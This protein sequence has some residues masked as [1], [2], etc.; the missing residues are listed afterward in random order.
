MRAKIGI[1]VAKIQVGVSKNQ[2]LPQ[3]DVSFSYTVDGLGGSHEDAFDQVTKNDYHEYAV[4]VEFELPVGNRARRAALQR[5]KLQYAQAIAGLKQA[6]EQ[7][8]LDTNTAVRQVKTALWQV[9]PSLNSANATEDQVDSII[10]RAERK[11]YLTLNNELSTRQA[12]AQ[13]RSSLLSSLIDYGIA[14]VD[15]ERSKGTLLKYNNI[16]LAFDDSDDPAN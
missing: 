14:V 4:G 5:S 8:I 9:E 12:L 11:D 16:D 13:A 7:V 3:L 2:A 6:L 15:L 1:D 10:A